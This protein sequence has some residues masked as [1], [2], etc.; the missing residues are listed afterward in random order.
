VITAFHLAI[1]LL[2]LS[3]ALA[4]VELDVLRV[5][6]MVLAVF[7]LGVLYRMRL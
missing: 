5:A 1:M 3:A 2:T 4:A 7:A 6:F